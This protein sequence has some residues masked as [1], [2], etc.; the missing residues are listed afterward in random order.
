MITQAWHTPM[1][2]QIVK[3]AIA[4]PKNKVQFQKGLSLQ[5]FQQL[6][7]A[8]EQCRAL[9]FQHRWPSGFIC[10]KC[11]HKHFYKLTSR[12]LYQCCSC[13]FQSSLISGTI[14]MSSKL[15]LTTWFLAIYLITQ[16]KDG[17]S[18]LNLSRCLGIS[19]NASLRLKHKLQ[20]VMKDADDA[21]P[22]YT[23]IQLDDAYWGG[24]KHDGVRGR[25]ATGKTPFVAAVSTNLQGHP[26]SMRLSRVASFSAK[27]IKHWARKHI[28]H[29]SLVLSDGLPGFKGVAAAGI[30]HKSI[31]TGG[32]YESMK[33]P[34]FSWVNIMLG[35]VKRSLH[36]TYHAVSQKHLPRY[37]A[38]FCY[39]FNRR[40]DMG[41]MISSLARAAINSKPIPQHRLKLAEE[42][43]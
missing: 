7:G 13:R 20:Q 4:M 14:F 24:K 31:V 34:A 35:N 6:Y 29:Q 33:I 36:G 28:D 5:Q 39:R 42:W 25:G 27:D 15:P 12:T 30:C 11:G 23:I 9:L 22:L 8:E 17:I 18:A 37:L 41:H 3:G 32:G 38:E 1:K 16:S 43:W 21:H 26:L 10:P 2:Q 40:F 19:A